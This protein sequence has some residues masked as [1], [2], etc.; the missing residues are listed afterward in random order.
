MPFDLETTARRVGHYKWL[1]M[2]LFEV[3]G[4]WTPTIP[5]PE[6]KVQLATHGHHHAWHAEL[7]HR[8]LPQ[9]G[10][11]DPDRFTGPPNR[12]L[13]AFTDALGELGAPEST[14]EKL[15]GVYRVLLPH[16]IAAYTFHLEQT[17]TVTDGPLIRCLELVLRDETEHWRQG[18]ALL[19]SLIDS[20]EAL[21]RAIAQQAR[22]GK[23][24]I[25]A[26]G[27]AGPGTLG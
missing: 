7:W 4:R 15:V 2:R 8:S 19:Q 17:A 6:A 20:P 1:E 12:D 25:A 24:L 14:I 21:D 3:L 9:L 10:D 18:E 27:V 23:L 22:L 26:G 11:S 16:T 13:V 5:E